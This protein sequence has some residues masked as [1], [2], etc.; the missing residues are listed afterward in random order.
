M[1]D[2]MQ[3]QL[4]QGR[5]NALRLQDSPTSLQREAIASNDRFRRDTA[6]TNERLERLTQNVESLQ[7]RVDPRNSVGRP[8][9]VISVLE[10]QAL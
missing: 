10:G 6:E 5:L 1:I 2:N 7:S 3:A 4:S 8:R 9:P